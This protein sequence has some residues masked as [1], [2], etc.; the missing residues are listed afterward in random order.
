MTAIRAILVTGVGALPVTAI[1]AILVTG[2]EAPSFLARRSE[3][4]L[5]LPLE[6]FHVQRPLTSSRARSEGGILW[7]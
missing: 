4:R 1:G 6:G 3:L 2:V 5:E 7:L